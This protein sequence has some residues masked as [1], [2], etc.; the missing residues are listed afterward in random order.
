MQHVSKI[1]FY[2]LIFTLSSFSFA[3]SV[4]EKSSEI[5]SQSIADKANFRIDINTAD[6]NDLSL[7]K[8]IGKKKAQAIVEYRNINGVFT[9]VDDLLKVNGI[10]K[11]ILNINKKMLSI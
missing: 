6:V 11:Q 8:G 10:G 9:S 4:K 2:C 3:D 1:L 7:L 5:K